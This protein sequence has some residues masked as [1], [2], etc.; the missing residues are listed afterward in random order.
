M[1]VEDKT[2]SRYSL[3]VEV[4]L[5]SIVVGLGVLL[6][7]PEPSYQNAYRSACKNN[8]KFLTVAMHHYRDTHLMFH[9]QKV[10]LEITSLRTVGVSHSCRMLMNRKL[11]TAINS[12]KPGMA[13]PK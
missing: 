4:V 8:L 11:L 10:I 13:L 2:G 12:M 9:Y 1:D 6:F 3:I 5:F 7:L